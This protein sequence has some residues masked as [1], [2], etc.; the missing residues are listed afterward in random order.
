MQSKWLMSVVAVVGMRAEIQLTSGGCVRVCL[1]QYSCRALRLV[2]GLIVH[3]TH[4]E[5]VFQASKNSRL[6]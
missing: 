3:F 2:S 6:C 5:G 1:P 4:A